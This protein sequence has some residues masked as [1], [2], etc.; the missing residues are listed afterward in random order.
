MRNS[1]SVSS[2]MLLLLAMFL[3][4]FCGCFGTSSGTEGSSLVKL[5]V[6]ESAVF[7]LRTTSHVLLDTFCFK[8]KLHLL[9]A[10]A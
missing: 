3:K 5:P 4:S 8:L 1:L 2:R 6:K 10:C 9:S 7:V